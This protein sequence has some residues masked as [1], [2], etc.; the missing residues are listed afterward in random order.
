MHKVFGSDSKQQP[1]DRFNRLFGFVAN[2]VK[3]DRM[4]QLSNGKTYDEFVLLADQTMEHLTWRYQ[5]VMNQLNSFTST[6]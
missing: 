4:W 1:N 5:D 6:H 3:R 2:W